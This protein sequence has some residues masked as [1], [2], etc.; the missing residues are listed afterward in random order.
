LLLVTILL[1]P[2]V[3]TVQLE[4]ILPGLPFYPV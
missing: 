3:Q 4:E 2:T 1:P